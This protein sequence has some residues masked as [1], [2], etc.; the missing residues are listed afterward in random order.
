MQQ[1]AINQGQA[2]TGGYEGFEAGYQGLDS[3]YQ[4][5]NSSM[6]IYFIYLILNSTYL[7]S[8]SLNIV[9]IIYYIK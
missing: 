7:N 9:C 2:N 1:P 3:L 5:I 8:I 4:G 6:F